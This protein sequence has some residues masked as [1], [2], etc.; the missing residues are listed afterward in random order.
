MPG[1]PAELLAIW[2]RSVFAVIRK[3]KAG[4]GRE[5]VD[6][7]IAVAQAAL[8]EGDTDAARLVVATQLSEKSFATVQMPAL[9]QVAA[10][11]AA[12]EYSEMIAR[13]DG[14]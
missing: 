7:A 4:S 3:G 8:A 14:L 13:L 11:A 12:A 10:S 6:S 5:G 1:S 2:E 9:E